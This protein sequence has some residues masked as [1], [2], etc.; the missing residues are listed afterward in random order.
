[1]K[2]DT[3]AIFLSF[4]VEKTHAAAGKQKRTLA[5]LT[6]TNA[7]RHVL[8]ANNN[9]KNKPKTKLLIYLCINQAFFF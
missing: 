4:F 6:S 3:L 7:L 8:K 9:L 5:D 1:M 2:S